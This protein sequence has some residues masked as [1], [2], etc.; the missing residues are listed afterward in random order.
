ME[1]PFRQWHYEINGEQR[2]P[3]SESDLLNLLAKQEITTD[4]LVWCSAMVE[5]AR[6]GETLEGA[7]KGG[8][9][10]EQDPSEDPLE[11]C[12]YSGEVHPR[13][14]ML[15]L[16]GGEWVH[17]DYRDSFVQQLS[18]GRSVDE[19][20]VDGAPFPPTLTLNSLLIQTGKIWAAQ[21]KEISL[22]ILIFWVP[23]Y[24]LIWVPFYILSSYG[25]VENLGDDE[26]AWSITSLG[27]WK[28]WELWIGS[29][30]TGGLFAMVYSLWQGGGRW[31]LGD[32]FRSGGRYYRKLLG[33]RLLLSLIGVGILLV[34]VLPIIFIPTLGILAILGGLFL[35]FLV[36]RMSLSSAMSILI[37]RGGWEPIRRSWQATRGHFWRLTWYRIV[38]Y[39][40][41]FVAILGWGLVWGLVSLF[42]LDVVSVTIFAF[43]YVTTAGG[44]AIFECVLATHMNERY[45]Q[46]QAVALPVTDSAIDT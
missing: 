41:V 28:L 15:P 7:L 4:T 13:S 6:L 18:E 31:N 1:D 36:T 32:L 45:L 43:I 17:P 42:L 24:I 46:T 27:L 30:M 35:P 14:R 33:T 16:F 23:F 20:A 9:A 5:W 22:I 25:L 3:V 11:K 34:F 2:G 10:L 12:S 19:D 37:D 29:L 44:L 26:A 8:G 39:G 40:M 21:W 38:V